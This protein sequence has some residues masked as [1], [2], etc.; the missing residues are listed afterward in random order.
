MPY[1]HM[2]AI[3][4]MKLTD[5]ANVFIMLMIAAVIQFEL[6]LDMLSCMQYRKILLNNIFDTA[7]QDSISLS[8]VVDK[9]NSYIEHKKAFEL[10]FDE[11]KR[12]IDVGEEDFPVM[13]VTDDEG[14]WVRHG[15]EDK[16]HNYSDASDRLQKTADIRN[17][18]EKIL[19][20]FSDYSAVTIS[21][22]MIEAEEWYNTVSDCGILT[23]YAVNMKKYK[24]SESGFGGYI[25]SGAAIVPHKKSALS[26]NRAVSI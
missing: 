9:N 16:W 11:V 3:S 2:E 17:A 5:F 18:V 24:R 15:G 25:V 4:A 26:E 1:V 23:I 13:L 12:T 14:F 6:Q 19:N 22:P 21:I 20:S 10:F 8:F 7:A